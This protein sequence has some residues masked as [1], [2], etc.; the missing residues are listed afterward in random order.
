MFGLDPVAW[1]LLVGVTVLGGCFQGSVGF[2]LS[3]TIVPF[4]SAVEPASIPTVPLLVAVPLLI[5]TLVRD[6]PHLDVSGSAWI[7]V[8]RLPGTVVGAGLLWLISP[9]LLAVLVGLV[10]LGSVA[11]ICIGVRP[12]VSRETQ[13][14]AGFASGVMGT[15]AGLGGPPISMVYRGESA[16]TM[17][18]TAGLAIFV[19]VFMSMAAVFATHRWDV[20]HAA[21]AASLLPGS[22]VGFLLSRVVNRHISRTWLQRG[23]LAFAAAAGAVA[24]AQALA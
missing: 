3:F 4:L 6:L 16:G 8:G 10:L 23:V 7:V 11:T 20:S 15:A 5:A 9:R 1:W 22:A 17:R 13:I 19:G 14:A 24:I 18:A 2:G 21:L 12:R